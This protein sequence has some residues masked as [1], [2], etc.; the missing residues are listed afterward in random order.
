MK[1][2][3]NTIAILDFYGLLLYKKEKDYSTIRNFIGDVG[4]L[5]MCNFDIKQVKIF[6]KTNSTANNS[7]YIRHFKKLIKTLKE[8]GL[9]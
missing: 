3:L 8:E 9:I 1:N 7:K 4:I 6:F 5:E 2:T